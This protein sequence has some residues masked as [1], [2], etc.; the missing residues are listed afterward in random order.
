MAHILTPVVF[1]HGLWLHASSWEDWLKLFRRLG[2]TTYAPGWP[3]EP[4]TIHEARLL[5]EDVAGKGIDDIIKHY[6]Q[7]I[8]QFDTLP[9]L[10]GHSFGG[11]I[12]QKLLGQDLAA[13]A[14]AISPAQFKGVW[15]LPLRQITASFPVF[16]HPLNYSRAVELTAHNFRYA[17]GNALSMEESTELYTRW[18]VPSPAKPLLEASIANFVP[19]SPAAVN[20]ENGERGPLLLIGAGR[21]NTVP[22]SVVR[23]QHK[24]YAKSPAIT[25]IQEFADRGHSLTID[26]GWREVA[27]ATTDWIKQRVRE[28][29]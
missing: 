11:L 27:D 2:Y 8:K 22:A 21:D 4:D 7:L 28:K 26:S 5:P 23:S 16:K 14:V 19:G 25:D 9:I 3:G 10:I 18:S 13:A 6:T 24:L 29:P 15:R 1:I 12:A 20:V 17:F